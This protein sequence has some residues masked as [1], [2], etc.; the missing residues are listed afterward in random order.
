MVLLGDIHVFYTTS[1]KVSYVIA[2]TLYLTCVENYHGLLYVKI[3]CSV[4]VNDRV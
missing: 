2:S 3:T 1:H 4:T